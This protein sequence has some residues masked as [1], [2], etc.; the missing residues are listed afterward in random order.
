MDFLKIYGLDIIPGKFGEFQKWVNEN[1]K[2]LSD[3]TPEGIE[4]L[5]IY[6]SVYYSADK[7]MGRVKVI[8]RMDSHGAEDR[9]AAATAVRDSKLAR[10]RA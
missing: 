7:K 8:F 10:L 1:E 4:L 5:D 2:A 6:V 3:A 9:F